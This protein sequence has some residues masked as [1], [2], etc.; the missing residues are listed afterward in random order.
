MRGGKIPFAIDATG[1]WRDV[2]DVARG[3]A[4]ACFCPDCRGPLVARKGEVRVHH[5][6][7]ADQRECRHALEASLFGMAMEQ[8]SRPGARL[9]LPGHG[10]REQWV[11]ASGV[12]L[13]PGKEMKFLATPWVIDC[14][15]ATCVDGFQINARSLSESNA[16]QPDF[17]APKLKLAVHVLS[18]RKTYGQLLGARVERSWR[19]LALNLSHYIK[20][21][22]ATCD[23]EKVEKIAEARAGEARLVRW[24]GDEFSGRGFLHHPEERER[25]RKF[26]K[27]L[28]S[29]RKAEARARIEEEQRQAAQTRRWT[30]PTEIGRAEP[31]SLVF[32]PVRSY[33]ASALTQWI[34]RNVHLKWSGTLHSW[35]FVGCPG[36]IVP[37]SARS[38]LDPE[39]PWAV[40]PEVESDTLESISHPNEHESVAEPQADQIL[41]TGVGSC[42]RCGAPTD[43]VLLGEGLFQGRIVERCSN[44][45]THPLKIVG[46]P[47]SQVSI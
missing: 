29:Q 39:A 20:I 43:R 14:G 11:R 32:K 6:A 37:E 12:R 31:S 19:I 27:W 13:D 10:S 36:Q 21:W 5:F 26:D 9:A 22:W 7:H 30:I 47:P 18:H 44:D 34:A 33:R 40:L 24:L 38:Y 15:Y 42:V 17:T 16:A 3:K 41:H 35:I 8:L 23:A 2:G 45:E 46:K 1:S 25:R 4:C 28:D